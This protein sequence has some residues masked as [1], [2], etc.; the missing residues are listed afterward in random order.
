MAVPDLAYAWKV[1]TTS[2][3]DVPMANKVIIV[4]IIASALEKIN[5]FYCIIDKETMSN[6]VF[7]IKL[8]N[9]HVLFDLDL[10]DGSNLKF[11]K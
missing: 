3:Y 6:T 9:L 11:D 10:S 2:S 8:R 5:R 7:Y 1:G 4:L